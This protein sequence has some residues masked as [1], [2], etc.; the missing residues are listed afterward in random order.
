MNTLKLIVTVALAIA[1]TGGMTACSEWTEQ[2][3]LP[4]VKPTVESENPDLYRQY[5]ENLRNYKKTHHQLLIGW[6]DNSNKAPGS[7]AWHLEALPD[8]TDIAV[9]L[10]GDNLADFERAEMDAIR[11]NK[12]TKTLYLIDYEAFRQGVEERNL[13]IEQINTAG[14]EAA[15][16]DGT[17]YVPIPFVDLAVELPGFMDRQLALL[18]KYGFDGLSIHFVGKGLLPAD[19]EAAMRELQHVIFGKLSAVIQS[20]A[21]KLFLFEG[22][23][24][25]VYDKS[26]LPAFDYIVLRT[27]KLDNI[28]SITEAAK[29]SVSLPGIPS[30][31]I[32][33]CAS[34]LSTDKTDL[35]TG[36]IVD[37]AGSAQNAIIEIAHW[38]KTPDTFTK[39]GLGIYRINDDYYNA[40]TDYKFT[41]EAIEILNP[42]SK[43]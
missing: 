17:T 25:N 16:A 5:L 28:Y 38:V 32:I 34:A 11:Q 23:P 8:K 18:D 9:L 3:I 43:N 14:Q 12:G 42:S 24:Q 19:E 27:E 7:R 13:E 33:V 15:D 20:H 10:D 35:I 36:T 21:G 39:A 22:L 6:F 41:R 26:L 29:R 1:L 4:V 40:E 37:A 2:E 30:G 31:N